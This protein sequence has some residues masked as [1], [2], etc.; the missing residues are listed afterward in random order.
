MSK[1]RRPGAEFKQGEDAAA[2]EVAASAG[3]VGYGKPPVH[4]RFQPGQSGNPRGRPKGSL[5]I[6]TIYLRALSS[7]VKVTVRGRP[8]YMTRLELAIE[9][10][11]N[12]AAKGDLKSWAAMLR[13]YG[14]HTPSEPPPQPEAPLEL[15]DDLV[16][17]LAEAALKAVQRAAPEQNSTEVSGEVADHG[18]V[19]RS[20]T[21]PARDRE[22]QP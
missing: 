7:R 19:T 10:L 4:S 2:S 6:R 21:R 14:D 18:D 3:Q 17:E 11:I 8:R 15:P 20:A 16:A 1:I 13:L 12:N 5:N 22:D 9:Q